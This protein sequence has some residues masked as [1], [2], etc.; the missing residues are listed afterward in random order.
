[1]CVLFCDQVLDFDTSSADAPDHMVWC[2]EDSVVLHWRGMGLLMVG[3]YGDWAR[4]DKSF[5]VLKFPYPPDATVLLCGEV[6]CCLVITDNS[7]DIMQ[8]VPPAL[9]A[10]S[11][12]GSTDPAAM[13]YDA[14]VA[15]EDGDPR[16]EEA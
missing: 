3:P 11:G 4:Y 1:V 7:C 2:G 5:G 9:E 13:L 14:A 8:R 10:T 6:D 12:I 16:A 15:F